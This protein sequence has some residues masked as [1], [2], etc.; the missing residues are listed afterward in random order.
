M[1][2][3]ERYWQLFDRDQALKALPP[4]FIDQSGLFA[5]EVFRLNQE[6]SRF[7]DIPTDLPDLLC[8]SPIEKDRI[9]KEAKDIHWALNYPS[10]S[11]P[12]N[13]LETTCSR[14]NLN[15]DACFVYNRLPRRDQERLQ[16][17]VD[18]DRFGKPA[19]VLEVLHTLPRNSYQTNVHNWH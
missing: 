14:I 17:Q 10:A 15:S 18:K 2:P 6:L 1:S 8:L 16:L 7:T 12:Q 5:Q 3:K 4:G 19:Y 11:M 9:D 13:F